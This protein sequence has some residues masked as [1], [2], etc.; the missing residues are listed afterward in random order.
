MARK[1]AKRAIKKHNKDFYIMIREGTAA[2]NLEAL[3]ELINMDKYKEWATF[4]TDDKHPEE[5]HEDGHIDH[6][7]RKAI[8]LGV[9]PVDAYITASYNAAKYFKLDELGS[10]EP[11]KKA[12]LVKYISK[13]MHKSR[14]RDQNLLEALPPAGRNSR[15]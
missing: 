6:I 1:K 8:S 13:S 11:N 12:N 3:Y 4:A 5:I 9:N 15:R 7:I 2:K 10:I 14:A